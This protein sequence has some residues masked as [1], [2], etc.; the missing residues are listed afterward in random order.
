METKDQLIKTIKEWVKLDNDIRKLQKELAQRKN[1]KKKLSNS[2]IDIMKKNEIDCFDI[3]NGQI[4]YNKKNIKKPITKKVLLDTLSKYYKGD[5]LKATEINNYILEN[6]EEITKES[7][8]LKPN[9]I[10]DNKLH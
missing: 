2:L 8:I 1:E 9:K 7:I 3:N 4:C 5:L 6:R 10:L